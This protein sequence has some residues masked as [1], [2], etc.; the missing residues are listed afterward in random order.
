[1]F[2]HFAKEKSDFLRK[3]DKSKKGHIDKDAV[4]II[5]EI[6][7]KKDYYT[8]SSC[9]GRIVLLEM[10]SKKKNECNWVFSKHDKVNLKEI[11]KSLENY[12]N[13]NNS[14][15]KLNTIN[16][17]IKNQIY[18]KQ[19]PIIL[20]VACRNLDAAN[21]LLGTSRKIFRIAG[22]IGVTKRRIVLEIISDER[23]E[24]IIADKDFAADEG[25]IEQLIK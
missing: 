3:K 19:Q 18:F 7:S 25:Y 4:K 21:I 15:K 11:K 8:T 1:M 10:K 16:K 24:T 5:N 23:L 17:K 12:I 6:N 9:S 2:N 22:I 14:I 13:K 20:H